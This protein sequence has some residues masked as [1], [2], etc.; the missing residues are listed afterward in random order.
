MPEARKKPCTICRRWFLPN[1]KVGARQR[2]CCE[3]ECQTARRKKTQ[4]QWRQRNPDYAAAYRLE[5]R[6]AQTQP[7]PEPL[8][9][10][11]PLPQ[12]PWD[13]AKD[14]FGAQGTDFLGVMSAL[15]LR[16]AKDQFLAYLVDPTR[17]PA[18]LPLSPQKTSSRPP[19][20]GPRTSG[21]DATGVSPSRPALETSASP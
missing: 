19:H 15:I 1:P 18:T 11:L 10:P 13:F 6:A 14:Q 17:L 5:Q 7:P 21:H 16:A 3:P 4:A 12:L 9:L 8:R 20:T 2:A